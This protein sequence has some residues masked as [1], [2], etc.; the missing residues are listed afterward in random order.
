[1]EDRTPIPLILIHKSPDQ[2]DIRYHRYEELGH[3]GFAKVFR[4]SL[5]GHKEVAIKVT[6][7]DRLV[8]PKAQQKHRTEVEIQKSLDNPNV[9]Q[10][11]DFFD[12]DHFTYLV[13]ELCSRG[14]LKIQLRKRVKFS[15]EETIRYLRQII[16]GVAYLHDN[17]ILHRDLKL[18][19]CLVDSTGCLKIADFGLSAKL[20]HDDERRFTVCGTPN[21]M[22]PEMISGGKGVSYEVDVWAIGVIA[23]GMLTG[24]MPF[25][26]ADKKET[27]ALIKKCAYSFPEHPRLSLPARQFITSI[28]QIDPQKRPS[29]RDLFE[30]P[31][32]AE[33]ASVYRPPLVEVRNSSRVK[34]QPTLTS[35]P[36]FFVSRFCDHSEKYGLGYLL[37]NGTVGACFNDSSRMVMDP[38]ENF[39]QYWDSYGVLQPAIMTVD[40]EIEKKKITILTRFAESLKKTATMFRIPPLKFERSTPMRH[41]KYWLRTE[42]ATLFRMDDRNIQVNFADRQKLFIFWGERELM[43]VPTVFDQGKLIALSEVSSQSAESDEKARFLVAKEMLAIM[44]RS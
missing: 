36:E 25:Q 24:K 9:L 2:K 1:M 38:Y 44:S 28:L 15:E 19:N 29:A 10:A 40:N 42:K 31:F 17:R 34:P 4:A 18:E 14:S 8:K 41:V 5:D 13:L 32:I 43:I 33:R 37:V 27:Y 11:V 7:K 39:I 12:D 20:E 22:C 23:F 3:G 16:A 30:H 21:Y 26:Q 6:S 35:V